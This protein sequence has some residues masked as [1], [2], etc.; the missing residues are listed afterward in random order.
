VSMSLVCAG[1]LVAA[2]LLLMIT[3]RRRPSL[4]VNEVVR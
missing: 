3:T 2:T 4:R 1:G